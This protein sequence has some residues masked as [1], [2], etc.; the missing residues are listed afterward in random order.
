MAPISDVFDDGAGGGGVPPWV[1]DPSRAYIMIRGR[2]TNIWG[3]GSRAVYFYDTTLDSFS[4]YNDTD[5][6]ESV[7][8]GIYS[9]QIA[10]NGKYYFYSSSGSPDKFVQYDPVADTWTAKSDPAFAF[11]KKYFSCRDETT[12][13]YAGDVTGTFKH[14]NTATNTWTAK[15]TA[16]VCGASFPSTLLRLGD[17][18]YLFDGQS[19]NYHTYDIPSNTW[20]TNAGVSPMGWFYYPCYG[21]DEA[22]YIYGM[23]TNA[24][25]G[26]A[27]YKFDGTTWTALATAK[28]G[29]VASS[30]GTSNRLIVYDGKVYSG[31]AAGDTGLYD[32][33]YSYEIYDIAGNSWSTSVAVSPISLIAGGTLL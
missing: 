15:A 29:S 24:L 13:L 28:G 27:F 10:A 12:G 14:Y 19:S 9:T 33:S 16:P 23:L 2:A 3:I 25:T 26:N 7:D 20:T 31:N 18:L 4:A 1:F 21:S 5:H 30:S 11:L 17:T 22:N 6:Y 8:V 32:Y